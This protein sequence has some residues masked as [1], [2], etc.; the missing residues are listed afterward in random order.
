[1]MPI[2]R[3]VRALILGFLAVCAPASSQGVPNGDDDDLRAASISVPITIQGEIASGAADCVALDKNLRDVADKAYKGWYERNRKYVDEG[4]RIRS[5][6]QA[7]LTD[8]KVRSKFAQDMDSLTLRAQSADVPGQILSGLPSMEGKVQFC[9]KLLQK[10]I[11]G[12]MDVPARNRPVADY[13][14]RRMSAQ[15][16]QQ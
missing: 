3:R 5:A 16:P 12:E 2:R 15:Q 4:N 10:T 13:L 14:D 8:E 1:M 7:S 9:Q 11:A 6:F